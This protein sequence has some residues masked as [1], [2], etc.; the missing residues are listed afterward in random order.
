MLLQI[1]LPYLKGFIKEKI[2]VK[3]IVDS[4]ADLKEGLR[5][6]LETVPLTVHFGSEEYPLPKSS[7]AI[8]KPSA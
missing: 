4:T 7:M 8:L 5:S 6:Q 1:S 3:L 2:M